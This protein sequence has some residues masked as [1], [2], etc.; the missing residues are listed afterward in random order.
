MNINW[1]WDR[2]ITDSQARRILKDPTNAKFISLAALLLARNNEP[3]KVF[4]N[5]IEPIEFC[6]YWPAIKRKM[7]ADKWN[8]PRIIFWQAVYEKV[9][10]KY[11]KRGVVFRKEAL[12]A[13]HLLYEEVGKRLSAIRHNQG[14]S[15]KELAVKLGV[16]QQLVSRIEKGRGNASLFTLNN[17]AR[18]LGRKTKVDFVE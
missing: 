5:Y 7:R 2:K 17:I 13:R 6:R 8:D 10:D 9:A 11:Q 4:K 15:Q 14:I 18:A 3:R 1:L 16:S 12:V